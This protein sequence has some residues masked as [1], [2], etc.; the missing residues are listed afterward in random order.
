MGLS[1][2]CAVCARR[3]PPDYYAFGSDPA[4]WVV[5]AILVFVLLVVVGNAYSGKRGT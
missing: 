2:L 4:M 1:R 5:P 3:L